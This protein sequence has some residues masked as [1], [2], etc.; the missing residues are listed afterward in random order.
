MHDIHLVNS[1]VTLTWISQP[2]V[3]Y[4]LQS[5]ASLSD[6]A[7]TD[8]SGDVVATSGVSSKTFSVGSA[9]N[10]YLRVAALP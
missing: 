6:P 7:W 5:K 1:S 8:V 9:V 10:G 2:G 3:T 4:R